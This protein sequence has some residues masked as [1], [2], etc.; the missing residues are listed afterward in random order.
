MKGGDLPELE[1]DPESNYLSGWLP[2][3]SEDTR[4]HPGQL[5]VA[6]DRG[7]GLIV[8]GANPMADQQEQERLPDYS[9]L[10]DPGEIF[11]LPPRACDFNVFIR[12]ELAGLAPA[13]LYDLN[14]VSISP[15]QY[16][17][18]LTA[19][20]RQLWMVQFPIALSYRRL[21]RWTACGPSTRT[22]IP[23]SSNRLTGSLTKA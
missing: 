6:T 17:T 4:A 13:A 22:G 1:D 20:L 10:S 21:P 18:T 3:E 11:I 7:S 8:R 2:P 14:Q 23:C 5:D 15:C 9:M 12:A 19:V 16:G